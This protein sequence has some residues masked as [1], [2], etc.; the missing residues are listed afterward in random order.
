MFNTYEERLQYLVTHSIIGE[1]TFGSHRYLNQN[2][3]RSNEWKSTRRKVI[4]RDGGCDLGLKD[5]PIRS[6]RI[7]VHHIEPITIEDIL[8]H[9]ID[10]L[11]DLENLITVS[12]RTHQAIHYGQSISDPNV[13]IERTP[14]D[15][16]PW[17]L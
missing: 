17:K 13:L 11:F 6:E 1:D 2:F 7:L 3:Y 10:K 16:C 15:T 12:D 4:V 8:D 9:R 5:Y 14:N